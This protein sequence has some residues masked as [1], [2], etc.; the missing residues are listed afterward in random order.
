PCCAECQPGRHHVRRLVRSD[1]TDM[2]LVGSHQ[3][4]N[5]MSAWLA[6]CAA[7]SE[8]EVPLAELTGALEHPQLAGRFHRVGN[9]IFDVAH[10]PAGLAVVA[11]TLR[12][13]DVPKPITALVGIL[14]DKD[15]RP[16]IE[17]LAGVATEIIATTPPTAPAERRWNLDDVSRFAREANV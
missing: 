11:G 2:G 5:V 12:Q 8:Y 4:A 16:M 14:G 3:P 9:V 1:E 7:G 6:L 13:L 15:W 10:N 17:S